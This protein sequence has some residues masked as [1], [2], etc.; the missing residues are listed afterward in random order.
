M[1]KKRASSME[2]R[3]I[4]EKKEKYDDTEEGKVQE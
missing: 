3:K 1:K 2:K 4:E